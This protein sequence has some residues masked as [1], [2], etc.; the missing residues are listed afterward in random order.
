M[1]LRLLWA[2]PAQVALPP[3]WLGPVWV[4]V[5]AGLAL[6]RQ[7]GVPAWETPYAEDG[8]VFLTDAYASEG[9]ATLLA[10]YNGYLHVVARLVAAAAAAV[11]VEHAAAVLA[12]ASAVVVGWAS[13]VVLQATA[14]LIPGPWRLVAPLAMV[15]SGPVA[16]ES[17][18]TIA[19]LHWFLTFAALPVLCWR[20]RTAGGWVGAVLVA[21]LAPLSSPLAVLWAPLAW[22]RLVL[23][24]PR[25]DRALGLAYLAACLLQVVSALGEGDADLTVPE[26]PG[27]D[28]QWLVGIYATRVVLPVALGRGGAQLWWQLGG[29]LTAGLAAGGLAILLMLAARHGPQRARVLGL[30]CVAASVLAFVVTIVLR[31][32]A[33]QVAL[34]WTAESQPLSASRYVVLPVLLLLLGLAIVAANALRNTGPAAR[35]W[36][37]AAAVVGLLLPALLDLRTATGRS[38]GPPWSREVRAAELTCGLGASVALLDTPPRDHPRRWAATVDCDRVLVTS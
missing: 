18:A 21:V 14:P 26:E 31:G 19:N 5:L 23:L 2:R 7:V 1:L 8:L 28:P 29:P 36:A 20:P 4:A 17:L 34:S 9:P 11:P 6:V 27:G 13:W 15:L 3:F 35:R 30:G 37:V 33:T 10:T 38:E 24:R 22:G 25:R 32:R 12:V 16:V